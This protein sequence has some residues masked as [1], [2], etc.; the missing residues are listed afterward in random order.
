MR[1]AHFIDNLEWS[2]GIE[3]YVLNLIPELSK[4]GVKQ[5]VI[6][7]QRKDNVDIDEYCKLY[8]N[9]SLNV[10]EVLKS[11]ADI[12]HIHNIFDRKK[13][14]KIKKDFEVIFTTHNYKLIC[15]ATNFYLKNTKEICNISCSWKCFFTSLR[16]R[17]MPLR[18]PHIFNSYNFSKW[19]MRN[20]DNISHIICPSKYAKKRHVEAG[21]DKSS[22]SVLPYFCSLPTVSNP[23]IPESKTVTF[24][25]R[26]R[27]YKGWEE[28]VK[29]VS[30][31]PEEIRGRMIGDFD[32]TKRE[33]VEEVAHELG[34]S[35]RLV[36]ENW[37]DRS[38]IRDV[39]DET[40]VFVFPS[41]WP[42]TLGI[43]GIEALASGVPVVG[44]DVGGVEE[45]LIDQKTG[46][47]AEAKDCKTAAGH[48][49]NIIYDE[50]AL[51]QMGKNGI[52]LV[53]SKFSLEK[54]IEKIA[55]IYQSLD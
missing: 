26:I 1:I 52:D 49:E 24:M 15:P 51:R 40:S 55:E 14:N 18:P 47:M 16:H 42:E 23:S 41:I 31:L 20:E 7:N 11:Q 25:G 30:M 44:F 45:W 19:A 53:K 39:F 33:K 6:Y 43:V 13:I 50:G 29:I 48:I 21:F 27:S 28:F 17:C 9:K 38:G 36:L 3:T 8:K 34:V 35:D 5:S 12:I 22:M 2:G 32:K 4:K 46:F 37:V 10:K 54:H